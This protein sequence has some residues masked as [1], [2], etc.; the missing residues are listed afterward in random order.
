MAR[1]RA[2]CSKTATT[3]CTPRGHL[4]AAQSGVEGLLAWPFDVATGKVTGDRKAIA[5]SVFSGYGISYLPVSAA[6]N[7]DVVYVSEPSTWNTEIGWFDL[8]GKRIA[9]LGPTAAYS[10][11]RIS[12]DGRSVAVGI[13]DLSSF[14][15]RPLGGRRRG[16]HAPEADFRRNALQWARL[17][18]GRPGGSPSCV[19]AEASR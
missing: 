8:A 16:R 12:P 14:S 2:W 11:G 19:A 9:T 5:R 17:V 18:A 4:L 15:H 3:P 1:D 10:A 13:T 6:E 7:G